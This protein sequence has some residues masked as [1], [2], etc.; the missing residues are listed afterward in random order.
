MDE[1]SQ[2]VVSALWI[3]REMVETNILDVL[4]DGTIARLELKKE[5][6]SV[7]IRREEPDQNF[8]ISK[9]AVVDPDRMEEALA[10]L[11]VHLREYYIYSIDVNCVDGSTAMLKI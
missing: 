8:T 11:T 5:P 9:L 1:G 7:I 2:G 6:I 10:T 4:P 3:V